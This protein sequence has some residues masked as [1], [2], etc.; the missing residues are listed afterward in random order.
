[1]ADFDTLPRMIRHHAR[2]RPNAAALSFEGRVTHYAELD[3]RSDQVA[4]GL[5]AL[6][7]KRDEHMVYLGKSSDYF[8]E[9]LIGAA[10]AGLI[11]TPVN[12]RLAVPEIAYIVRDC[13]APILFYGREFAEAAAILAAECPSLRLRIAMEEAAPGTLHYPEWRNGQPDT[14]PDIRVVP[15]DVA[16]QLYTSGTTG[17]PKG[18]MI[19]HRNLLD[20]IHAMKGASGYEWNVWTSDDVSL[21][22]MPVGH[23]SGINWAVMTFFA[24]ASA[25]VAREF[26]PGAVI[27]FIE[28]DRVS[29]MALVPSALQFVLRDPR[30]RKADF[31][32]MRYV[33][34]GGSIMPPDV[35]RDAME[36]IGCGFVQGY[37]MTETAGGI[38]ILG[39]DDHSLPP[40]PR[41]R[42][43]G[44][45]V[46]GVDVKIVDENGR[47][48]G[49][50][51]NGEIAVRSTAN[52]A[53][54]WNLPE[55]TSQALDVD[56]WLY[57]GD[58]GFVDEDGYLYIRDRV[59]DM[60]ITGGENV[61]PAEVENVIREHPGVEDVAV[62]GLPDEKWGE[63]VVAIV[64]PRPPMSPAPRDIIEQARKRI[65]GFKL[66]KRIEFIGALPRNAAGKVSKRELREIYSRC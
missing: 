22:S 3:R 13:A 44:R 64:V 37:G 15:E 56:G 42:S 32:R 53:G 33:I 26:N 7:L 14:A 5:R 49:A 47:T 46:P 19:R 57:T 52:M 63:V 41:M 65:A 21:L 58:A 27:D 35:M 23:I 30:A 1:M 36:I 40:T 59:K 8:F 66:P 61:Y 29:R 18:V 62:I 54:Y 48:L 25:V 31:S 55:E 28:R 6:E 45:P 17:R 43:V 16:V 2:L 12:W 34:Y 10:R 60:I 11:P 20:P 51:Q 38:S 9:L 50:G 4:N 24:G 39:P